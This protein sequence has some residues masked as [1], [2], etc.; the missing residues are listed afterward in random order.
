MALAE[1][2]LHKYVMHRRLFPKGFM[3]WVFEEHH[4]EHHKKNRYDIN[5]S[6]PI[7]YHL[8]LSSP[9]IIVLYLY[10][11]PSLIA[12]LLVITYHSIF[13]T[14]LHKSTHDLQSNWTEKLPW[15][16]S[17]RQH[18]LD[19]HTNPNK[20]FAVVF[21]ITDTIFGTKFDSK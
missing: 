4:I 6:L 13:W 5:I 17:M 19:H 16:Q 2:W 1:R 14:S 10:S 9:V 21:P 12:W 11:I 3:D 15:Y 20:N 18:H 8:I 7:W